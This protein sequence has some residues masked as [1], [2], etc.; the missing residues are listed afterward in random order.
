MVRHSRINRP[1]QWGIIA[2][3]FSQGASGVD[4]AARTVDAGFALTVS[5]G[6]IKL[7]DGAI[8]TGT[9]ATALTTSTGSI[10]DADGDDAVSQISASDLSLTASASGGTIGATGAGAIDVT[11]TGNL[12][13]AASTGS[14]GIFVSETG[15]LAL[16]SVDAGSGDIELN[17]TSSISLSGNATTAG[18]LTLGVSDAG[19]SFTLGSSNTGVSGNNVSITA[20]DMILNSGGTGISATADLTVETSSASRGIVLGAE[21]AGSLSLTDTELDELTAATLIVGNKG[22][23]GAITIS[24]ALDLDNNTEILSAATGAGLVAL[25]ANISA[26]G[27]DFT[28]DTLGGITSASETVIDTSGSGGGDDGGAVNVTA[29]GEVNIEAVNASGADDGA[30]PGGAGGTVDISTTAGGGAISVASINTS[31]GDGGST[32]GASAGGAGGEGSVGGSGGDVIISTVDGSVVVAGI[33]VDGGDGSVAYSA[34]AADGGDAGNIS[35]TAGGSI[36]DGITLKDALNASG[37]A[38]SDIGSSGDDG[39]ATLSGSEGGI[40]QDSTSGIIIAGALSITST[41]AVDIDS[42][43]STVGTLAVSAAGQTVDFSNSGNI[44]IGSVGSVDGVTAGDFTLNVA[45]ALTVDEAIISS[46]DVSLS[47]DA[48]TINAAITATS[49]SDQ[50]VTLAPTTGGTATQIDA[51]DSEGVL[52][53]SDAEIDFVSTDLLVIGDSGA[54]AIAITG[55]GLDAANASAVHLISSS[56]VSDNGSA[57]INA[58]NLAITAGDTVT[59][60]N[61]A[62][63]AIGILAVSA[64]GQTVSVTENTDDL[65]VGSVAGVDGIAGGDVTLTLSSDGGLLTLSETLTATGATLTADEMEITGVISAGG[66]DVVISTATNGDS[67]DLGSST[68]AVAGTLELSAAE[69]GNITANSLTIGDSSAGAIAVTAAIDVSA[70]G[71][72]NL[73]SS[74]GISQNASGG[75]TADGFSV[76]ARGAVDLDNATNDVSRLAFD[77][78]D[79]LFNFANTGSFAVDDVGGITSSVAGSANITANGALTIE[80]GL[81]TDGTAG[82]YADGGIYVNAEISASDAVTMNSDTD[83]TDGGVLSVSVGGSVTSGD[84]MD[85]TAGD[86]TLYTGGGAVLN[87]GSYAM[88]ITDSDGDGIGLGGTVVSNGLNIASAELGVIYAGGGLDLNT[89]GSVTVDGISDTSSDGVYDVTV[90]AGGT[91]GFSSNASTFDALSVNADQG[92]DIS[93]DLITDN[94]GMALDG[95][96]ND[97]DDGGDDAIDMADGVTL[98]AQGSLTLDSTTGGIDGAGALTLEAVDGI[99]LNDAFT[100]AGTTTINADTNA[101]DGGT[102]TT[103][104]GASINTAGNLLDITADDIDFGETVTAGAMTI[105]DSDGGGIG[106]GDTPV[107]LDISA[108][109]L[110]GITATSLALNSDG[111]V[112]VDN[113]SAVNSV[114]VNEV[115]ISA[116]GTVGFSADASSF[117]ALTVNADQGIDIG[118][119]LFTDTGNM[120]L[121]GDANNS[122]NDGDDAIDIAAGVTLSSAG[123]LTLS[124]ASGGILGAGALTLNADDGISVDDNLSTG[125]TTTIDAD[126]GDNGAGSFTLG[127]NTSLDTASNSLLVTAADVILDA[128]SIVDAGSSSAT[129]NVSDGGAIDL[130]GDSS[131]NFELS[132][133]E[134]D[135]IS[136]GLLVIGDSAGGDITLTGDVSSGATDTIHLQTGGTVSDGAATSGIAVTNLAISAGGSVTLEGDNDVDVLAVELSGTGDIEFYDSDDLEIGSVDGA[137]TVS[138]LTTFGSSITVEAAGTVTLSSAVSAA[139]DGSVN[140]T[141]TGGGDIDVNTAISTSGGGIYLDASGGVTS[142]A[143]STIDTDGGLVDIEAGTKID[144]YGTIDTSGGATGGSVTINALGGRAYI[145]DSSTAITTGGGLVNID[146]SSYVYLTG[147]IDTTGGDGDG[148][149]YIDAAGGRVY[150]DDSITTGGGDVS[151]NATGDIDI[152][153]SITTNGGGI[154]LDAG[155]EASNSSLGTLTSGGG[156]I[157]VEGESVNLNGAISSSGGAIEIYGE[158]GSVYINDGAEITS[159]TG[160]VTVSASQS[161]DVSDSITTTGGGIYIDASGSFGFSSS[162]DGTL[163]SGG[164]RIEIYGD[165]VYLNAAINSGGGDVEIDGEGGVAYVNGGGSITSGGGEV[166]IY[167]SGN[168]VIDGAI[169]SST[170]NVII[171]SHTYVDVADSITTTGG[172]VTVNSYDDVALKTDGDIYSGGGTV[173]VTADSNSDE[174]GSGDALT[175]NADALISAGAGEISLNADEDVTV[176]QLLTSSNSNVAVSITSTSGAVVDATGAANGIDAVNGRLVISAV[177][178]VGSSGDPLE[179]IA[180]SLDVE[181]TGSGDIVLTDTVS[182]DVVDLSNDGSGNISLTTTGGGDITV[183]SSGEGVSSQAGSVTLDAS[184]SVALNNFVATT[185]GAVNIDAVGGV[186]SDGNGAVTTAGGAIT[187][188]TTGTDTDISLAGDIDTS[189]NDA[190]GATP[191]GEG[192]SVTL[193]DLVSS[194]GGDGSTNGTNGTVTITA[195]ANVT[196]SN[197]AS[198]SI[199]GGSLVIS[200]QTGVS[201]SAIET[202]VD[203]LDITTVS[204]EIDILEADDVIALNLTNDGA[205]GITLATAADGSGN[206]TVAGGETPTIDS[207]GGLVT[208]NA[209]G[210]IDMYG[211]IA[212][213]G[214]TVDIDANTGVSGNANATITTTAGGEGVAGGAVYIDV[215]EA[216]DVSLTGAIDT[217]GASGAVTGGEGGLVTIDTYD[218]NIDVADITSSGG[219]ASTGGS[220]GNVTLTTAAGSEGSGNII[221]SGTVTASAGGEGGSDGTVDLNAV[222]AVIDGNGAGL[223]IDAGHLDID[224]DTGIGSGE[225]IETAV[226]TLYAVNSA[227]GNIEITETDSIDVQHIDQDAGS[228]SVIISAG[229]NILVSDSSAASVHSVSGSVTLNAGGFVDVDDEFSTEGGD[230]NIDATA[231]NVSIDA[232]I[233][234]SGGDVDIEAGSYVDV[235]VAIDSSGGEG[236]NVD[237]DAYGGSI[238]LNVDGEITTGGGDVSA[239]ATANINLYESIATAGGGIY[240]TAGSTVYSDASGSLTSGGGT[241]DIE[242][243]DVSFNGALVSSGGDGGDVFIDA[244]DGNFDLNDGASITTGGGDVSANATANINLY[245][246]IAT[247]GG[248]IYLDADSDMS[249]NASGTLTSG[250]G[251]IDINGAAVYLNAALNSSGGEGGNIEIDADDGAIYVYDGASVTTGGGDVSAGA[252]GGISLYDGIGSSGGAI[253][254]EAEGEIYSGASGALTSGGGLVDIRASTYIDLNA[255]INSSGGEGSNVNIDAYGGDIFVYAGA[256]ISTGGGDVSG[257]ATGSISL[258]DSIISSG[259]DIYL[260]GGTSVYSDASGSIVSGGGRVDIEADTY[261]DLNASIVTD[262]GAVAVDASTGMTTSAAGTITT[263]GDSDGETSGSVNITV[264]GSGAIDLVG[265]I[266]TAGAALGGEGGNVAIGTFDGNIDVIDIT[267]TGGESANARGDAGSITIDTDAGNITLNGVITAL[268]GAGSEGDGGNGAVGLYAGGAVIDANSSDPDILAGSL[269]IRADDGVGSD[270]GVIETSVDALDVYNYDSGSIAIVESDDV[271]V[272]GLV[273]TAGGESGFIDFD[274]TDGTITVAAGGGTANGTIRATGSGAIDVTAGGDGSAIVLNN[275]SVT[276]QE[277]TL[278]L[279]ADTDIVVTTDAGSEISADG[280]VVLT[281]ESIGVDS[282]GGLTSGGLDITGDGSDVSTLFVTSEDSGANNIDIDVLAENF[283]LVQLELGSADSSANVEQGSGGATSDSLVITSINDGADSEVTALDTSEFAT[284]FNFQQTAPDANLVLAQGAAKLGGDIDL[285]STGDIVL[286]DGFGG[287]VIDVYADGVAISL[288]ADSDGEVGGAIVNPNGG[289]IAFGDSTGGSLALSASDGIGAEDET[290]EITGSAGS[291]YFAAETE[292]G[293]VVINSSGNVELTV[294]EIGPL[295]GISTGTRDVTLQVDAL[296]IEQGVS[297]GRVVLTTVTAA[298]SI[299]LGSDNSGALGL[300]ED[301]LDLLSADQLEIGDAGNEGGINISAAVSFTDAGHD[302]VHLR[303]GSGGISDDESSAVQVGG[304]AITTGGEV[305]LDGFNQVDTLAV[306]HTGGEGSVSFNDFNALEIGSVDGV[307]GVNAYDVTLSAGGAI[308]DDGDNIITAETVSLA[309]AATVGS[310]ENILEIDASEISVFDIG[311]AIFLSASDGG[312]I[313]L[314][315]ESGVTIGSVTTTGDV[316]IAAEGAVVNIEDNSGAVIVANNL[317]IDAGSV[318]AVEDA[319]VMDVTTVD[320]TAAGNILLDAAGEGGITI[321]AA[322]VDA[323][324]GIVINSTNE[325]VTLDGASTENGGIL[326]GVDANIYAEDVSAGTAVEGDGDVFL[327]SLADVIVGD[328]SA[329]GDSVVIGASGDIIMNE[330]DGAAAAAVGLS[331]G[332]EIG[333]DETSLSVSADL[334]T[335]VAGGVAG[336]GIFLSESDDVTV[337]ELAAYGDIVVEADTLTLSDVTV[338]AEGDVT[339]DAGVTVD[340]DVAVLTYESDGDINFNGGGSSASDEATLTLAAGAGDINFEGDSFAT[341]ADPLG[342]LNVVSAENFT[343]ATT[344]D[345]F[346]LDVSDIDISGTVDLG[347]AL[348]VLGEDA[349]TISATDIFGGLTAP[350]AESATILA[351]GIIGEVDAGFSIDN[352]FVANTTGPLNFFATGGVIDGDFGGGDVLGF[353]WLGELDGSTFVINGVTVVFEPP[354]DSVVG[355]IDPGEVID[356]IASDPIVPNSEVDLGSPIALQSSSAFVADVFSVDFSPGTDLTVAPAAGGDGEGGSEDGGDNFLGNF[357]DDLI[358]TAPEE[359]TSETGEGVEDDTDGDDLFAD[360]D[361]LFDDEFDGFD[362]D[363]DDDEEAFNQEDDEEEDIFGDE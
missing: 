232:A 236:G 204:G 39:T 258:Y 166:D 112:T 49:G 86:I 149:V 152:N 66:G 139:T 80:H 108:A 273:N 59:L 294:T 25:D 297:G 136:A 243:D 46:G 253:Y 31:G 272:N 233:T 157:D 221:L 226:T 87:S 163:T 191:G 67:I 88:T 122:D 280:E 254:L 69:L 315:S 119:N 148:D 344:L 196:D 197:G 262:G 277:G 224:A 9:A 45:S 308:S 291:L 303:T 58:A 177:T 38:E 245:D 168:V 21:T 127:A 333:N 32:S 12:T 132:D 100:T 142:N 228:S 48:M 68:N 264:S 335:A 304:L 213:N 19:G 6:G 73:I 198:L 214:G 293:D 290:V 307:D 286:G 1:L 158:D 319:L 71:D 153:D 265:S 171:N 17:A 109:E 203:D 155:G 188:N 121:D 241:I 355:E 342:Q 334:L 89:A 210:S 348:V 183:V 285:S 187:I 151:G 43:N 8:D 209:D 237:I 41:G 218:G 35:L 313:E 362:G 346:T 359:D 5:N 242:G 27:R 246:S 117:D 322:V 331:A 180:A 326:V 216:G 337:T 208:L 118:G 65:I 268:G 47:A 212:S 353:G 193:N 252:T 70:L 33:D 144:L 349:I 360:D 263:K 141:A 77:A 105:T 260:D 54:G 84:I 101:A 230:V 2:P 172:D 175:M 347:Q 312:T 247:S 60:D 104:A 98:G 160:N 320:V 295:T 23:G 269:T 16:T 90:N 336:G 97:T 138:G 96:A 44:T 332:G 357:W 50:S 235:N 56:G 202:A 178:G 251:T 249:G 343:I 289:V 20:D 316:S 306:Y 185:G 217:S 279:E 15:A 137:T 169:S 78:E 173:T 302:V 13:A 267:S 146:A 111:N 275:D 110:E 225:A 129:F 229:G 75:I 259:G 298:R 165:A 305:V 248:G 190:T 11:L 325:A 83:E 239:N 323:N 134:I 339:F 211:P 292:Y 103:S 227:S 199:E 28:I 91:V 256:E 309:N 135:N 330:G 123:S 61:T 93:G 106:L 128:T 51:D 131:S 345:V 95:D 328:V 150:I 79:Q 82:L 120:V 14:G 4:L 116:G 161:I 363:E 130:G 40:T 147:A 238:D 81:S 352:P 22:N 223:N 10:T 358:E 92:I 62:G 205:G 194:L 99:T 287:A 361:D 159:G 195:G 300:R 278:T 215:N 115:T 55:T 24:S 206:I 145:N 257:S 52:G 299:N 327:T 107:G 64:D 18:D 3:P 74:A 270:G 261:V 133:S 281:A 318:G 53:L 162:S 30:N 76:T 72:T 317:T 310:A 186:T 255:A 113:I 301:E 231:Y 176:G 266:D 311:G 219:D 284:R 338:F 222:D 57:S 321:A 276:T 124:A 250:G 288:T 182:V 351:T 85:I 125:G 154:F 179:T 184:G 167:A 324:G 356:T 341:E 329:L 102:L 26:R 314:T 143:S 34:S 164:G 354:A 37:G 244:T 7:G 36:G 234:T 114:T 181:N 94:G 296:E 140:V 63:V 207:G 126:S 29:V 189:G 282:S 192:G 274:T 201:G 340:G 200:A 283:D 170:G 42:A 174:N 271:A 240:L 350:N 220:A 156:V